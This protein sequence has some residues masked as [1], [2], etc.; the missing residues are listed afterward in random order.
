MGR[1]LFGVVSTVLSTITVVGCGSAAA[2]RG[3][4]L[5]GAGPVDGA[6]AEPSGTAP[7]AMP[8]VVSAVPVVARSVVPPRRARRPGIERTNLVGKPLDYASL[9]LMEPTAQCRAVAD[10]ASTTPC[11]SRTFRV[12][13]VS[14]P[15]KCKPGQ[16][17]EPHDEWV[18]SGTML[19]GAVASRSVVRVGGTTIE[20]Q[21]MIRRSF[22]DPRRT[23]LR[24][25]IAA[26]SRAADDP[27]PFQWTT[28]DFAG[29]AARMDGASLHVAQTD[30]TFVEV[31]PESLSFTGSAKMEREVDAVPLVPGEVYGYRV[32]VENCSVPLGN[33]NR[34]ERVGLI[35]PAAGWFGATDVAIDASL[36]IYRPF[37]EL[38]TKVTPGA[39]ASVI[40]D[41]PARHPTKHEMF[42]PLAVVTST[43]M[44]D[45]VWT[46]GDTPELTLYV[47]AFDAAVGTV[48]SLLP[49]AP[50]LDSCWDLE[51]PIQ[52][53]PWIRP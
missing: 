17:G 49:E 36:G 10:G 27:L 35:A 2:P 25:G 41:Y 38:S 11:T 1:P 44:L 42:G 28:A 21:E 45:V 52:I 51:P 7:S 26:R 12:Q 31:S 53:A 39:S 43:A 34:V 32:C 8:Q 6:G 22:D 33:P 40:V 9:P 5:D 18:S 50:F 24:L 30:G 4:S 29:A 13:R 23:L 48:G 47:G 3:T 16:A 14:V 15:A 19:D 37:T 46:D 20:L